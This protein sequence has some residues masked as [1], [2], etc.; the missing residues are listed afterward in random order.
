ELIHHVGL[1]LFDELR[2]QG[3]RFFLRLYVVLLQKLLEAL[4]RLRVLND[5]F[6]ARF[7]LRTHVRARTA[8]LKGDECGPLLDLIGG[9]GLVVDQHGDGKPTF[10][11]PRLGAWVDELDVG[12]RLSEKHRLRGFRCNCGAAGGEQGSPGSENDGTDENGH[13]LSRQRKRVDTTG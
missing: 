9:D 11:A 1:E 8:A 2:L 6:P 7:R 5:R 12:R 13:W 10:G 4:V 3:A